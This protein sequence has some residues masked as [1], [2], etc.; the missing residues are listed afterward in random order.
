MYKYF[1][2]LL[3]FCLFTVALLSSLSSYAQVKTIERF[4]G[5]AWG[6][7][8]DDIKQ[9]MS[10]FSYVE[11]DEKKLV[12]PRRSLTKEEI[13][14]IFDGKD[15]SKQKKHAL[16][17]TVTGFAVSHK[18]FE[19]DNECGFFTE[20]RLIKGQYELADVDGLHNPDKVESLISALN[21]KYGEYISING[22]TKRLQYY[23]LYV[24]YEFRDLYWFAEDGTYVKLRFGIVV[25]AEEPIFKPEAKLKNGQIGKV[26][27]LYSGVS[28]IEIVESTPP[29]ELGI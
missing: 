25:N 3:G 16:G 1:K 15:T 13:D 20:C 17:E 10:E 23:Y 26:T 22:S 5:F 11:E 24:D 28:D 27:L 4:S 7:T 12:F 29:K 19:F 21:S 8:A 18:V 2:A 9:R 6:L 14:A